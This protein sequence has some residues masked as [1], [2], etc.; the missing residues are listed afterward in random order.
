MEPVSYFFASM[1]LEMSIGSFESRGFSIWEGDLQGVSEREICAA[2][3]QECRGRF[4]LASRRERR[5][6]NS[7]DSAT[8]VS[9]RSSPSWREPGN[10]GRCNRDRWARKAPPPCKH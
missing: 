3:W 10:G 7:L 8:V 5:D 2:H 4:Y 9:A 6:G 1:R